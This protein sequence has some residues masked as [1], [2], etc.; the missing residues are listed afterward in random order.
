MTY[1]GKI[2]C[3]I[4][5]TVADGVI[6]D[7]IHEMQMKDIQAEQESLELKLPAFQSKILR[8]HNT[9]LSVEQ[10]IENVK[11]CLNVEKLIP[12]ILNKKWLAWNG[13]FR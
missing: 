5:V 11:A 1:A 12:F 3:F 4:G 2:V 6:D 8:Q 10:F 13:I 9:E 7:R